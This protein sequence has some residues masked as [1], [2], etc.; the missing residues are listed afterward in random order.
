MP[1][2]SQRR[3]GE[4]AL[5]SVSRKPRRLPNRV[6]LHARGGWGKSSF[7]AQIPG[8][9]FRMN[10]DETGLWTL[11][12][13]GQVPD[14]L[15]H[16]P[17]PTQT[18]HDILM[19]NAELAVKD[20]AY[21]ALVD[22]SATQIS[23]ILAEKVCKEQYGGD[24]KEFTDW[25][26]DKSSKIIAAEWDEILAGYDRLR[27]RGI[28]VFLIS[29]S[30]VVNF[31]NP[32]GPDYERWQG[33]MDKHSWKRLYDWADMV[34]FGDLTTKV[35]KINRN[36]SDAE[37]KGKATGGE[38]RVLLTQWRAT[39]DA[40]NRHGLPYEIDCGESAT[41]AWAAFVAALKAGK[42]SASPQS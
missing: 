33:A 39:H 41:E 42:Q 14:N 32:S 27:E 1:V 38:D 11:M 4:F 23:R 37:T 2:N 9:I 20:H 22:D 40:K 3:G 21:K 16:F 5:E 35:A 15:P 7:A 12:E 26:G 28:G 30:N 34:L 17:K 8:A 31:K 29:H 25:G 6:I 10:G 24:W 13:S 18:K 36:K 19:S